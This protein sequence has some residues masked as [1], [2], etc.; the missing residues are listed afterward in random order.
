MT[1]EPN[2]PLNQPGKI[3]RPHQGRSLTD[4]E[5]VEILDAYTKT[6]E[7]VQSISARFGIK[8]TY[9]YNVLDRV[10]VSWRRS[11]PESYETWQ[12][13]QAQ[14]ARTERDPFD[15]VP[16]ETEKALENMLRMPPAREPVAP[17]VD[18]TRRPAI[19]PTVLKT[20]WAVEVSGT[21]YL[22][23]QTIEAAVTEARR[24]FPG[25]EI[26]SARQLD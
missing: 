21:I 7:S 3:G 20:R 2:T 23:A 15:H 25:T 6:D 1:E 10:G 9:I 22:D 24:L 5:R 19:L 8:D 14:P 17:A 18:T 26:K 4:D 11:N 12:A 16:P 13:R